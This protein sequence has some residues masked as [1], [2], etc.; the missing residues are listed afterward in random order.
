MVHKTLHKRLSNT[1]PV[2]KIGSE[3]LYNTNGN[4]SEYCPISDTIGVTLILKM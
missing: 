3:H 4:T 2:L 1:K